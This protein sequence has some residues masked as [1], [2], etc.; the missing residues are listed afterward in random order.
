MLVLLNGKRFR[1]LLDDLG[2]KSEES[3]RR[4]LQHRVE[5]DHPESLLLLVFRRDSDR[6]DTAEGVAHK[7]V[8]R[9]E[10]VELR[11]EVLH[12]GCNR[13]V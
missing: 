12:K 4:E 10:S 5:K 3:G 8:E 13:V 1:D 11:D 6:Y 2:A 9:R 7:Q